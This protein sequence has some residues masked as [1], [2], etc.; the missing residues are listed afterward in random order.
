MQTIYIDV[1]NL[2]TI[3]FLTGIQR[4]VRNVSIE[5]YKIIPDRLCFMAFDDK[6]GYFRILNSKLFI[7]HIKGNE[8]N[9]ELFTGQNLELHD[10]KPGDI[11]FEIDAA[12]NMPYKRSVLLPRLKQYGVRIAVYIYDI[13]PIT[14]PQYAHFGTRFNFMNYIGAYLQ[15]ADVLIVSAKSTLDAIYELADKLELPYIPGFVSWLGSDF[16]KSDEKLLNENAENVSAVP[17]EVIEAA[18]GTFILNVGT[19]EP[20]KN[21]S[22]LIDAFDNKLF[23][24]G[25]K[26][27]FAGKIGWNVDE[28]KQ[29]IENHPKLGSSFFHFVGLSDE[30]LDYLYNHAYMVAFPTFNEGFGLPIIESLERG[31]PV[32]ASDVPVL[33]EVGK[34]YC[35]YFNPNDS[36]DFI[37]KLESYLND[38]DKYEQ[39]RE[40]IKNFK[41]F[42]WRETAEKIIE[43]LDYLKKEQYSPKKN[44]SQMVVLTARVDDISRSIPFVEAYMPFIER[45]LL[46]CPD[47]VAEEMKNISTKRVKIEVFTDSEILEGRELP[48]DHST[49]NF[50]L[51]RLAMKSSKIDE[52]FIMSDDDYRPLRT[53]DLDFFV[54]DNSYKAYYCNELNEWKGIVGSLTSYDRL[55]FRTR[56]FVNRNRYPAYQYSSHMPQIID[57]ELY[58]EMLE[59]HPEI[60]DTSVD[61][62]CSYFNYVQAKYPD[63]I[64]SRPYVTMC[65]PGLP[66]DWRMRIKPTEYVFENFYEDLYKKGEIFEGLST[67]YN[68]NTLKE[69]LEKIDRITKQNNQYFE[70]AKVYKKYCDKVKKDRLE[71]P[72]FG[73]YCTD[74]G[75]RIGVP[76]EV[77]L[78]A[79][80]VIHIPFLFKGD[81]E[82][83]SLQLAISNNKGIIMKTQIMQLV[84]DDLKLV[85]YNFDVVLRCGEIGTRKGNYQM[86]IRIDD[87]K[88]TVE[89]AVPLKLV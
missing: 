79:E 61:E 73:I 83:L 3:S 16:I 69:N 30:A 39:T 25:I 74:D 8:I 38:K 1:T 85:N 31:T 86:T 68:D 75:I 63:L 50:L 4:V 13:I 36:N 65:W 26:L 48:K 88:D 52:V 67:E 12:W 45:I 35:E 53:V 64:E 28:L 34:D 56:D 2:T 17:E 54:D 21:H 33:R 5:M 51:R 80:A 22:L 9:G 46:C 81:K 78:P 70:W 71:I 66:S 19:I 59:E 77:E 47:K 58:L 20:R 14:H 76:E 60:Q 37:S 82:G 18:K 89:R 11:F 55:H 41:P 32:L 42:T 7:E 29:R 40:R 72:S 49:R 44:V 57:K 27:I 84:L 10:M 6:E 87:G 24:E 15:Y 23:D 43:A 62:W